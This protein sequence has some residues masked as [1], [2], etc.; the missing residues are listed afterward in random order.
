MYHTAP[1]CTT[2]HRTATQNA[3]V[4]LV[5]LRPS[6]PWVC[7]LQHTAT[8][9]NTLHHT[10][11][12]YTATHCNALQHITPHCNT[13]R[14]SVSRFT[15]LFTPIGMHSATHCNIQKHTNT[16]A[17][18]LQETTTH[19]N[20]LQ[21]TATHCN[22][23][24]QKVRWG[25][26]LYLASHPLACTLQHTATHCNTLQ[27]TAT[28]NVVVCLALL[29]PSHLWVCAH[30]RTHISIHTHSQGLRDMTQRADEMS[31]EVYISFYARCFLTQGMQHC[32]YH[33]K[34]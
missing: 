25:V 11:Q 24:Q 3:A 15:S 12:T 31:R 7:T 19:C 21:H 20:T 16:H 9:C 26:V 22:T 34:V 14:G 28:E 27:H 6:C 17:H 1:H 23:M 30:I 10:K 32:G 8:H 13:Q 29:R 5:L 33:Q 4:C 2:L 18:T